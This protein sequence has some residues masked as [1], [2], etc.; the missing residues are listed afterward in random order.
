MESLAQT[1][2]GFFRT[3]HQR[4]LAVASEV[5]EAGLQH[6]PDGTNSLGWN[7]WHVARFA[8]LVQFELAGSAPAFIE[9]LGPARQLWYAEELAARWGLDASRLGRWETGWEMPEDV[10]HGLKI[11]RGELLDYAERATAALDRVLDLIDGTNVLSEYTSPFGGAAHTYA[12]IIV[13]HTVHV[14]RHLGMMECLRGQLTGSGT[15]TA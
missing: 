8:D 7:L 2:V 6:R 3:A 14:N 10:A 11:P 4:V 15:A 12:G 5:D 9:R 1:L 13:R